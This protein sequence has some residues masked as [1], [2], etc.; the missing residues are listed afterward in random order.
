MTLRVAL[1]AVL[2]AVAMA[3]P[4]AAAPGDPRL[5]AVRSFAFAIGDG[6]LDR[7]IAGYDLIVVDGEEATR[8]RVAALGAGGAIVLAYLSVG[9]IERGRSWFPRARRYRLERWDDWGEWYAD[10]NRP[11]F[12]RLIASRV[13]PAML[14]KGFDGLFLDNT[15][16]VATH[17]RH[18]RGMRTLVERLSRLVDARGAYLFTQNGEEEIGP[19]L[20]HF[21]GWNREDVTAT[22]DFDRRRYA[23]VRPR[24]TRS[25]Q[26]ALRRIAA[27]GLL[28]TTTDYTRRASDPAA[29]DA[30]ANACAAGAIPFVSDIGLRRLPATPFACP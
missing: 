27:G 11:G 12:R 25:A 22:Y 28:V 20:A 1:L 7:D 18:R 17:R 6:A 3:G 26:A 13:A 23:R 30:V 15:D 16:M 24:D 4:A 19:L 14:D 10:V 8:E 29:V 2:A 21:D 9:T 5:A